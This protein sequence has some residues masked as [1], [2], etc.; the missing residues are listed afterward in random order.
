LDTSDIVSDYVPS[1]SKN[2][3]IINAKKIVDNAFVK[4]LDDLDEK[5]VKN[6]VN[7]VDLSKKMMEEKVY[8]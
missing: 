8:M 5:D 1:Y 6:F 7:S 2:K 3:D 4:V